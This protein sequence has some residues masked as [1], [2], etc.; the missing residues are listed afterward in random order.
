MIVKK[1]APPGTMNVL[2]KEKKNSYSY[3]VSFKT[4]GLLQH[5]PPPFP[6]LI[7]SNNLL[8]IN[9]DRYNIISRGRLLY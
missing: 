7:D 6:L 1:I 8:V 4:V 2:K 9:D 3:F 5:P